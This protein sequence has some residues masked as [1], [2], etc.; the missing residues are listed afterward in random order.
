MTIIP[1]GS[2]YPRKEEILVLA[3]GLTSHNLRDRASLSPETARPP[4]KE[5]DQAI[6]QAIN[7]A[8]VRIFSL[9]SN[10]MC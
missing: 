4:H 2:Q 5:F 3:G 1:V 6:H 10:S 8:D 7:I 9:L